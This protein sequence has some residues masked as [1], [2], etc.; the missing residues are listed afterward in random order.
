[1]PSNDHEDA[2]TFQLLFPFFNDT[3]GLVLKAQGRWQ[4]RKLSSRQSE[5]TYTRA[6]SPTGS[7]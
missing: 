3:H 7:S 4:I 6:K 1:M 5:V 2:G